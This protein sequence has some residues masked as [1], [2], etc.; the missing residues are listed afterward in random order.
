MAR[1]AASILER[2]KNTEFRSLPTEDFCEKQRRVRRVE[3]SPINQPSIGLSRREEMKLDEPAKQTS[4]S[5]SSLKLRD[6]ESQ[7][8]EVL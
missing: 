4:L 1:Y 2:F 6:I 7:K 5:C 8:I 3:L